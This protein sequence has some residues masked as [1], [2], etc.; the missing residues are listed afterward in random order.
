[1]YKVY[2]FDWGNTIMVDFPDEKGP[3]YLWSKVKL[4]KNAKKTLLMLNKKRKKCYLATNAKDSA[5]TEIIKALKRVNIDKYFVDIF[6]F[7]EIKYEKST[8]E[9]YKTV[10]ENINE[11]NCVMIGD[12]LETDI[13][14]SVKNCIDAILFDPNDNYRDYKGKK[15]KDLLELIN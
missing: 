9:F 10:K 3:M 13:I 12:N 15:I 14:N 4:I 7:N 1:M 11:D 5:K 8:N 6:C 2:L